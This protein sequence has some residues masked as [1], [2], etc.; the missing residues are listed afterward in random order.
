M[1][2]LALRQEMK[3]AA[4]E[5]FDVKACGARKR[6]LFH[7]SYGKRFHFAKTGSRLQT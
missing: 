7:V 5:S 4:I 2:S 6:P 3:L 1:A